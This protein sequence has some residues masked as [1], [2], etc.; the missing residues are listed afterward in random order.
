ML[1]LA[2]KGHILLENCPTIC[3][4][5]SV[6]PKP[7]R[8]VKLAFMSFAIILAPMIAAADIALDFTEGP[9][10]ISDNYSVDDGPDSDFPHKERGEAGHHC[11]GCHIHAI[12]SCRLHSP[13][14]RSHM[15][16]RF[17]MAASAHALHRADGLFRPPRS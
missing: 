17:P 11:A 5:R 14:T 15:A 16:R 6:A 7:C 4:S 2:L 8:L 10:E 12:G 3:M 9:A 13:I 1:V